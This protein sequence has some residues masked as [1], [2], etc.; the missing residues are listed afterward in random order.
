MFYFDTSFL[1]PLL[2]VEATSAR[3]ERFIAGLHRDRLAT[4]HWTRVEF[5]SAL[6]ERYEW[7]GSTRA[8]LPRS[9]FVSRR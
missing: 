6:G 9:V 7:A 4:S 5:S 1:V 3:I 2:F 8:M